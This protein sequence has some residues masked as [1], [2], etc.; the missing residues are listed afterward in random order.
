MQS[1]S[2]LAH[3]EVLAAGRGRSNCQTLFGMEK[4]P[5]DN[6]ADLNARPP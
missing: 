5:S 3:R 6:H 1:P 2:F 4:I